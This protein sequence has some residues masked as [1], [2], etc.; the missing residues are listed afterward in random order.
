[1]YINVNQYRSVNMILI[2]R[3]LALAAETF[4]AILLF[5]VMKIFN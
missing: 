5:G 1:M 4:P 3:I 2:S